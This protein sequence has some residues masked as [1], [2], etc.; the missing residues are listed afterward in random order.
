MHGWSAYSHRVGDEATL[1]GELGTAPYFTKAHVQVHAHVSTAYTSATLVLRVCYCAVLELHFP[2][3]ICHE[4]VVKC[5][6]LECLGGV[7]NCGNKFSPS[8]S[9]R[10]E[11]CEFLMTIKLLN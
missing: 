7:F 4:N 10:H 11:V 1:R 8:L 9:Q 2:E 6:S 3:V 5:F